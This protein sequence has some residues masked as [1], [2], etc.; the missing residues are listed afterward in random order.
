MLSDEQLPPVHF[1]QAS[2]FRC[3]AQG[4]PSRAEFSDAL[5]QRSLCTSLSVA[6]LSVLPLL[7]S[8]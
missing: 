1:A 3:S 6:R 2:T 5:C 4:W 7:H 8:P